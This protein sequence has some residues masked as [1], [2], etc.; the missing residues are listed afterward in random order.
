MQLTREQLLQFVFSVDALIP[1]KAA[2]AFAFQKG[3][4]SPVKAGIK[5]TPP[6]SSISKE[7]LCCHLHCQSILNYFLV[8]SKL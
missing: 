6:E 4:P 1:I 8:P 7:R 2:R 5:A 3:G